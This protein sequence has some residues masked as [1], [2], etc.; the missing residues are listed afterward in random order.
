MRTVS[1]PT[2]L[3]RDEAV[4]LQRELAPRVER[5]DRLDELRY[6]AG[7]DVS[8]S[9]FTS[10][11]R[12]AVVVLA[13]PDLSVVEVARADRQLT[14]PY[15][16]GLLSFRE[17][18]VILAAMEALATRPDLLFIDGHGI[19]HPR[20][21]GIAAHLGVLL[22]LPS[23]GVAKSVLCGE[24]A[25]LADEVGA[26]SELIDWGQV[27]GMALRTRRNANP[28]FVSTGHRVSMPTAVKL[29]E[30][31]LRGYRLPE[32]TRLAHNHAKLAVTPP[33]TAQDATEYG[34]SR[35][36]RW[37]INSA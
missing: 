4:Q 23:I 29:V 31:C 5:E 13:W 37:D 21:L 20:R 9:R 2:D 3:T 6:V 10:E 24:Y 11:G 19:A 30:A 36:V 35:E 27:I 1:I 17:A 16:P 32:P 28:I 12:A 14:L 25:A 15:I 34:A 7:V 26:R 18:P 22:D 33:P 8:A